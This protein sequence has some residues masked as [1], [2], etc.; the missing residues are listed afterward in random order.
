MLTKFFAPLL[1]GG[2]FLVQTAIAGPAE[3]G[4]YL[5][6]AAGCQACHTA[7][8]GAPFAGGRALKTPFGTFF[9]PNITPDAKT[10]IGR[11]SKADFRTALKQGLNPEGDHYFPA[12]PYTSY[13]RMSPDD[14]GK[15]YAYLQSLPAVNQP[16]KEHDVGAPFSWRFLQAGW[17]I[18]F[19]DEADAVQKTPKAGPERGKYLVD[20]LGHCGE[21]HTPRNSLGGLDKSLYLAGAA[22]GGEGELVSNITPDKETGIGDWTKL[23]IASFLETGMKPNFDDVQGSMEEVISH[24]TS[25]LTKEDREAMADYLSSIPAIHNK[26]EKQQD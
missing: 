10:G 12:F 14:M 5:T 11:W 13:T 18:L 3:E 17:K 15:I 16:N 7:K 1:V 20:A 23:D 19:F 21:C 8:G 6:A 9:S 26:I 4:A 24:G 22:G 25:K 2:A